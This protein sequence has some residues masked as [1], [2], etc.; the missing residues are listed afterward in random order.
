MLTFGECKE[1][2]VDFMRAVARG[3]LMILVVYCDLIV[4]FGASAARR[5]RGL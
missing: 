4:A 3:V 2:A 5:L 1:C